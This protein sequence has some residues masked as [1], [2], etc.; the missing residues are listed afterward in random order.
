VWDV[1][2]FGLAGATGRVDDVRGVIRRCAQRHT[3]SE[4]LDHALGVVK[5]KSA[6]TAA[7]VVSEVNNLGDENA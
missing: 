5:H 6:D 3:D 2:A 4:A 7:A 1:D